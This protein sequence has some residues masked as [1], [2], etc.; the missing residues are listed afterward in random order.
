MCI[1]GG[2]GRRPPGPPGGGGALGG[3]GCFASCGGASGCTCARVVARRV[4]ASALG[5]RLRARTRRLRLVGLERAKRQAGRV[6]RARRRVSCFLYSTVPKPSQTL[7]PSW[8]ECAGRLRR[9]KARAS[10]TP[11]ARASRRSG[12]RGAPLISSFL[13]QI[14]TPTVWRAP[15]A[16]L[17][18]V[19]WLQRR[20]AGR[21]RAADTGHGLLLRRAKS[22]RTCGKASASRQPRKMRV[23][24]M[25]D[26]KRRAAPRRAR[27]PQDRWLGVPLAGSHCEGERR[28]RQS[29]LTTPAPP[30]SCRTLG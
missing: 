1:G 15:R 22:L 7:H 17:A 27:Q 2:P 24:K 12:R 4:S 10:G 26:A 14:V 29:Q 9:A 6:W 3:A 16:A 28:A 30:L 20:E 8:L 5:R 25:L 11:A 13:S 21:T 23:A 18:N 19:R